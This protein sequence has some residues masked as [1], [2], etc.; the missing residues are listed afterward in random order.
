VF[1]LVRGGSREVDL[2]EGKTRAGAVMTHLGQLPSFAHFVVGYTFELG[3]R[4]KK[5][6]LT[7][8]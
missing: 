2:S 4:F 5:N 6:K 8:F 1:Q 3:S 7:G